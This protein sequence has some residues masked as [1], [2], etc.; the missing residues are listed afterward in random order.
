MEIMKLLLI[1]FKKGGLL[2]KKIKITLS[3]PL[4]GLSKGKTFMIE[5][6]DDATI[7][8]VLAEVDRQ[9]KQKPKESIF[10][11]YDDYIHNYLQLFVNLDDDIIYEDVGMSAY[12]PDDEGVLRK[13]NPLRKDL[14]F[15]LYP[16]TI[17]D[18]QQ[19]V[20]C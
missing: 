10:P 2:M 6:K 19:D 7:I 16:D 3:V 14:Y 8:D 18:L 13:F 17:I 20:G 11:L 4:Q 5:T 12:G 1:T 9:V 15:N